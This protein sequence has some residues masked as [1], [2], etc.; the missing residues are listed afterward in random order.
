[1]FVLPLI[2]AALY[3]GIGFAV[4]KEPRFIAG[5]KG[6]LNSIDG[7]AKLKRAAHIL[8]YNLIICSIITIICCYLSYYLGLDKILYIVSLIL[9][10]LVALI[11][12]MK[13]MNK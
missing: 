9:P 8:C 2:L 6:I 3:V 12:S 13:K 1:M 10:L 11:V 5:Y 4:K 7:E